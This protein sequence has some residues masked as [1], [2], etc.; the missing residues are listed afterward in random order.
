MHFTCD[1]T[2]LSVLINVYSRKHL[3]NSLMI[4]YLAYVG[5]KNT[6]GKVYSLT[7]ITLILCAVSSFCNFNACKC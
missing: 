7:K 4:S 3:I 1:Y 5:Q 6:S 2:I